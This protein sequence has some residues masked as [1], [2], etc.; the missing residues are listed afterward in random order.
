MILSRRKGVTLV[1]SMI[2]ILLLSTLLVSILGAFYI[3]KLSTSRA[4][5]RMIAMNTI[6]QYMEQELKAGYHE[7]QVDIDYYVTVD[8]VTPVSVTI[9]DRDTAGTSDDLVGTIR[10]SPYPAT[11]QTVGT[12]RYKT[13]GFVV[14]WTEDVFGS[15]AAQVCTE[16][17]VTNVAE[18]S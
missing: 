15:G 6:R 9:D 13:I 3:S 5:H 11:I 10:P 17:A 16:R 8:S 1:E 14:E 2:S 18:H 4:K 7:G 12:S